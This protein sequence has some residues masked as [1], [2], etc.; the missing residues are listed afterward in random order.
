MTS[1]KRRAQDQDIEQLAHA[2]SRWRNARE[3]REHREHNRSTHR[4]DVYLS[5]S[6]TSE[7][8]SRVN[9]KRLLKLICN[10][11]DIEDVTMTSSPGWEFQH[12]VLRIETSIDWCEHHKQPERSPNTA[13]GTQFFTP[14]TPASTVVTNEQQGFASN[15]QNTSCSRCISSHL[16]SSAGFGGAHDW[17]SSSRCRPRKHRSF[18]GDPI[19]A[20]P[21]PQAEG[22]NV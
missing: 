15:K 20:R 16:I 13:T 22:T 9:T 10:T 3:H 18:S 19:L 5:G 1:W 17:G 2:A 14:T 21:M 8:Q 11:I 7:F 4:L 12:P 6:M